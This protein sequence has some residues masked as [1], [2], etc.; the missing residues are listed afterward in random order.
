[1]ELYVE[2]EPQGSATPGKLF[3]EKQEFCFTLEDE[4]R[5][6]G[7]KVDGATAIP[8]GRYRLIL[9]YSNRFKRITPEVV[10]VP[11]FT[12]IRIHGGNTTADTEGCLLVGKDRNGTRISNCAPALDSLLPLV[13]RALKSGDEVYITY[14]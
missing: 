10:A 2:R 7:V 8:A 3:V 14:R 6:P 1:M 9:T 13:D 11:G 12:A 5:A 4:V